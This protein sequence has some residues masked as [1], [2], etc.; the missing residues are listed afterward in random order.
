[1]AAHRIYQIDAFTRDLFAGN[2]A[3]VCPLDAWPD[4]DLLQAIAQENNLSE[5][6]FF[7]PEGS[8][9]GQSYRLR[10]FTP[11]KEVSLCGHATLASAYVILTEIDRTSEAVHFETES[12]PLAAKRDGDRIAMDFPARRLEQCEPPG[13]LVEGIRLE[14]REVLAVSPGRSLVLVYSSE[15]EVRSIWPD[16]GHLAA[17]GRSVGITAPGDHSDCASRYFAPH[18]GVPEDPVTGSIHCALVPY[19][20][21][22]LGKREI[23]ARQVSRRGGELFCED[24]GQR[25]GIAGHAVKYMEGVLDL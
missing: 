20:A 2:P 22:R 13:P 4:D 25:V 12:G 11:V 5:T 10:W 24:R 23:Y 14:P 19:W 9:E 15:E 16:F 18:A 7:V 1:M 21:A 6:A 17:L 8:P 3:A